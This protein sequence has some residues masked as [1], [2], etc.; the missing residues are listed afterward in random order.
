MELA[1]VKEKRVIKP[2]AFGPPVIGSFALD[3]DEDIPTISWDKCREQFATRFTENHKGLFFCHE[4]NESQRCAS[5]L[6]KTE[7]IIDISSSHS[8]FG[9]TNRPDVTW[10][11]PSF[12]WMSSD[13]RRQLL[14]ILL[15]AGMSYDPIKDNYE[16]ALWKPD[17]LGNDYAARTKSAVLRF[18]YGFTE[19]VPDKCV[20]STLWGT[21]NNKVGWVNV[22]EGKD[23]QSVRKQL[24]T[25]NDKRQSCLIGIG[26]LWG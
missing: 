17:K 9:E 4:V 1:Y 13:M 25:P 7:Q 24:I 23:Q 15:R 22:F 2:S 8:V 6:V 5:F 20:Q 14:T 12:F 26:K 10:I 3:A 21:F 19:F 16:E 18:L 11:V